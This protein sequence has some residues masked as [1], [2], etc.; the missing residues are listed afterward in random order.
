MII[1]QVAMIIF[2]SVYHIHKATFFSATT[3]TKFSTFFVKRNLCVS[4]RF[5]VRQWPNK[6][7]TLFVHSSI[8][9]SSDVFHYLLYM[10]IHIVSPGLLFWSVYFSYGFMSCLLCLLVFD[11]QKTHLSGKRIFDDLVPFLWISLLPVFAIENWQ[12]SLI[13]M[14]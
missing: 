13:E 4:L 7:S 1:N 3:S 9:T 12:F 8:Q 11:L 10:N 14:T 5:H 2:F 6:S